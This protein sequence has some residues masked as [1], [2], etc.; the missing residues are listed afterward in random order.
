[1]LP[2]EPV[3]PEL[4]ATLTSHDKVILQA[5]PGA[6]K[7]TF[8][9]LQLVK[10]KIFTGRIIM[11]EPRRLAARSI[12]EYLAQ[13]LGEQVG[14]TVGY[15]VRQDVKVSSSTVLEIVTEGIL[16]RM[17]QSDPELSGVDLVIFDEFH[18]RSQHADL[19][20]AL[21]LDMQSALRDDLTLLIMSATLDSE[22]LSKMLDAPI[23]TSEG[24]SYP[25]EVR[26]LPGSSPGKAD[27][28]V[29]RIS[30]LIAQ[31]L[32]EETGSIL[33]FLPGAKEIN[34]L[35]DAL[36]GQNLSANVKVYPLYGDLA[37]KQQQAAIAPCIGDERK[38]VIAT[39]IAETSLTIDGIR[40]VIDSGLKR[41]ASFNPK[42][43]V[44]KL[45]TAAIAKSSA[46]QR[47][48]R[49]GRLMPGI[50]YRLDSAEIFERRMDFD[51]PEIL[52]SDLMSLVL[53]VAN[54]G[55]E[56]DDMQ[57]VNAP[58]KHLVA[59]AQQL[60]MQLEIFDSHLKIT[61]IG[62]QV[63]ALGCHP[64]IA[65]M[66]LKAKTLGSAA[67]LAVDSLACYL[68]AIIEEV[69]PLPKGMRRDN[70]SI[71]ARV[72]WVQ[73]GKSPQVLNQA[74]VWA[75]RI[76]IR[77][78]QSLPLEYCGV[79]LALAFPDR[80]AKSRGM[81]FQMSNGFGIVISDNDPLSHEAFLVVA[82]LIEFDTRASVR[83]AAPISAEQI[84]AEL[85]HLVSSEDFVGWDK[86][87]E[88]LVAE[89]Q[90]KL[91]RIVLDTKPTSGG[92]SSGQRV[93]AFIGRI[94]DKGLDL[95]AWDD[96][97]KQ[98]R[99]RLN[100]AFSL[101]H[102]NGQNSDSRWPA[103][104]DAALLAT[105]D[106]WLAPYLNNLRSLAELKKFDIKPALLSRLEWQQQQQ[107][108][109]DFPERF[110][111]PTGAHYKIE[112]RVDQSPKLSVRIQEMFGLT[113]NP[114]LANG[115]L[116]LVIELL[117]P[118]R[119]PLQLTQDLAGF[120]QGSY[121]QVK[122]EMKGRYPRHYWPDDPA[123]A[124]PTSRTKKKMA[125]GNN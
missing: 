68:A 49:A 5:P 104:S 112:Y 60:M 23:I 63:N 45:H 122:K 8:L 80:I 106:D 87:G 13:Q 21:S 4:F 100:T 32:L 108:D 92:I 86:K 39:N 59:Q 43:G 71:E 24:R 82:D 12:A 58:P 38:I 90:S 19:A 98:L 75:K 72:R 81:G 41:H 89:T 42:N 51:Q 35:A 96:D 40:I 34:G 7:S 29:G 26:Y 66:L 114:A 103:Y 67:D 33:V 3:L 31:L 93:A 105:L 2:I 15:R 25:V 120:W 1:M 56:I 61:P 124:M 48:G 9:P 91:G 50:C 6:G 107:L 76:N 78:Q 118:A 88:K 121:E 74:K 16:T 53:E 79:L 125:G 77:L 64:R 101:Y 57:W 37:K 115:Q 46:I 102:Q 85:A 83:L 84:T 73:A 95:L 111:V 65:H 44:T 55:A 30:S 70:S 27:Q 17:I 10:Q 116:P 69:D 22:Y 18:E 52:I 54:W 119:K 47:A 117:S 110:K 20:L 113:S 123:I 94:K 11:L 14:Q 109:K 99:L 62:H 97:S 28:M 36:A